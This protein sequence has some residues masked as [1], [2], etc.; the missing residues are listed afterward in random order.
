[1]LTQLRHELPSFTPVV[2]TDVSGACGT[3]PLLILPLQTG[4]SLGN[5]A[6]RR[7]SAFFDR[8]TCKQ[9]GCPS[10]LLLPTRWLRAPYVSNTHPVY[11]SAKSPHP[12]CLFG[13]CHV[14]LTTL[15]SNQKFDNTWTTTYCNHRTCYV[16]LLA[17]LCFH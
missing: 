10:S 1:M 11:Q 13:T 16:T 2:S 14:S 9:P 6:C 4:V 7:G 8:W 5:G 3:P 17:L 15:L 12:S